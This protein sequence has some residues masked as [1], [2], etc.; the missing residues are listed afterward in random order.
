MDCQRRQS[1]CHMGALLLLCLAVGG[2]GCERPDIGPRPNSQDIFDL[3]NTYLYT[4]RKDLP[5]KARELC[6]RQ[7]GGKRTPSRKEWDTASKQWCHLGKIDVTVRSIK[8]KRH[9]W[10]ADVTIDLE[11]YPLPVRSQ[12]IHPGLD[13]S[14]GT[15]RPTSST[16]R[17]RWYVAWDQDKLKF[18]KRFS[19]GLY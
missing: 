6:W 14:F 17:A 13:V 2:W 11:M 15:C 19:S 9:Y 16:A 18:S 10:V 7:D 3:H 1:S 5:E 8:A 4:L 12:G